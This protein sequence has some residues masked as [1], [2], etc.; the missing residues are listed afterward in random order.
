M[1]VRSE[2]HLDFTEMVAEREA[3]RAD[4]EILGS[5]PVGSSRPL[6]SAVPFTAS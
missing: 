5:R 3:A 2:D 1:W 4:T 6:S